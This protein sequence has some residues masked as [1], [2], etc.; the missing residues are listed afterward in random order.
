MFRKIENSSVLVLIFVAVFFVIFGYATSLSRVTDFMIFCIFVLGFDLLYGHM[1]RLSFG[2]MLYLGAGA[3]GCAVFS[4]HVYPDP[5]LS[6]LAGIV[7]GGLVAAL[8]GLIVVN[9]S[10]AAFALLNLAFNQVGLFLVLSPL[11]KWTGGEDGISLFFN[12]YGFIIFY[13]PTFWFLFVLGCLLLVTFLIWRL[14]RSPYGNLLKA[15]K[16]NEPRAKFLGYNTYLFKYITF[17]FAGAIAAFAGSL[18]SINIYYCNVSMIE[19]ARNVE[20]IF[21]ALIGGAGSV[22]GA[23]IGGVAYMTLSNYLAMYILRWEMFLG[24][25][26]LVFVFWFRKGIW[27]YLSKI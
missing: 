10:H 12:N 23:I 2:H 13:N 17:V 22:L 24:F 20:V 27:G 6:I 14:I 16:E 8:L 21:A 26:L 7:T 4:Y 11:D 25:A 15:I 9:T 5:F 3:Y 19:T 18:M 1:G